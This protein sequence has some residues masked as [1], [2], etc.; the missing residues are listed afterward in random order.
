MKTRT[1]P[2]GTVEVESEAK[3]SAASKGP[4]SGS[5]RRIEIEPAVNGG[6]VVNIC[7]HDCGIS[8]V[9]EPPALMAFADMDAALAKVKSLLGGDPAKDDEME[10][11]EA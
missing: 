2:D 6:V 10:M 9:Y 1:L 5:I 4:K 7:R 3:D 11:D 8:M